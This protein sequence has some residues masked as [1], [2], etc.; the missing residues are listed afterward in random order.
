MQLYQ[1]LEQVQM[2]VIKLLKE[3]TNTHE[4]TVFQLA[5]LAENVLPYPKKTPEEF[6]DFYE[7]GYICDVSEGHGPYAPRYIL[8]DYEKLFKNGCKH[9]RLDPPTNLMEALHTLLIFYRSVPSVTHF[10]VYMGQI[11]ELLEPFI[12]GE[13]GEKE[14]I[15]WFLIHC[16]RTMG[17]SFCHMNLGP[18]DTKAGRL[19]LDCA[20]KL[21][22]PVPNMTFFYDPEVTTDEYAKCALAAA[23]DSA[24]PAIAYLPAYRKDY[25]NHP[26]GIASCYNGLPIG[27]G[28]FSLA[29]IRLSKIG[30]DSKNLADLLDH[31][32]PEVV[33]V[34]CEFMEAKIDFLVKETPFFEHHFLVQEE[35][36]RLEDFLGLFGVVGLAD[37]VND[38][39]IKENLSGR[40]GLDAEADQIGLAIMDQLE[41]LVWSWK[42]KYSEKWGSHFWL[43]AQV[44]AEGDEGTT[45]GVRIPIGEEPELYEH[46][47]HAA[48]Y[49]KYFPT[50][51]GDIFP[52]DSTAKKNLQGILDII[53]GSFACGMRYFSVYEQDGET[54]RVTGYLVKKS[55][56]NRVEN[57][58]A[59]VNETTKGSYNSREFDK[60]QKRKVRTIDTG[61]DSSCI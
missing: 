55:E 29:R 16:D 43:H 17:S 7:K 34:F 32:L 1:D 57:M 33:R 47:R 45:P 51:V 25:H 8:P 59:V 50:G 13:P 24:N 35:F 2:D 15:R 49:H 40:Y 21:K 3:E 19:V 46:I 14:Q 11:D 58:E 28:A 12:K 60:A 61:I 39:M 18:N 48:L 54:I 44:G 22:N 31:K 9:L 53:K 4:Q 38:M 5:K 41:T 20:A 23:L 52:F 42:S 6:F 10:P 36:I 26:V 27:G 30:K 56:V 37:C